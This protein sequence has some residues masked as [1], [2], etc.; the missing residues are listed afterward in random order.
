MSADGKWACS[1]DIQGWISSGHVPDIRDVSSQVRFQ[2]SKSPDIHK[3]G[4]ECTRG[5]PGSVPTGIW[6]PNVTPR[7]V[8]ILSHGSP[9]SAS[10]K[11][12]GQTSTH[13]YLPWWILM[14]THRYPYQE[15]K[16]SIYISSQSTLTDYYATIRLWLCCFCRF[17]LLLR[18]FGLILKWIDDSFFQNHTF[19][20]EPR[21]QNSSRT[22][23]IVR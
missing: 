9:G 22:C 10:Q 6:V 12:T 3:A 17:L 2:I 7:S 1:M 11:P 15:V 20:L 19:Q 18:A 16:E 5:W 4:H 21:S 13:R 23:R 14:G 8:K